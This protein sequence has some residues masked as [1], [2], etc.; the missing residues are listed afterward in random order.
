LSVQNLE[1]LA[2]LD[3]SNFRKSLPE[4]FRIKTHPNS[5]YLDAPTPAIDMTAKFHEEL[6]NVEEGMAIA[7]QALDLV[8]AAV[9]TA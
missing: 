8:E 1:K 9:R 5:T 4:G 7:R 3:I 2:I 6:E